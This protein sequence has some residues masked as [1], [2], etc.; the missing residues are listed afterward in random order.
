MFHN[1][2]IWCYYFI[3]LVTGIYNTRMYNNIEGRTKEDLP[4]CMQNVPRK[5]ERR[6]R[7]ISERIHLLP[8]KK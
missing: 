1:D 3:R 5:L 6:K 8:R 4:K 2:E 7:K